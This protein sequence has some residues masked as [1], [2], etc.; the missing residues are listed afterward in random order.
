MTKTKDTALVS[1]EQEAAALAEFNKGMNTNEGTK[2]N[3]IKLINSKLVQGEANPDYGKL[4]VTTNGEDVLCDPA[5]FEF[6][7]LKFR[8]RANTKKRED[9][10][11][12]FY[13]S[14]EDVIPFKKAMITIFDSNTKEQLERGAYKDLKEKYDLTYVAVM[15]G[16]I[17][18]NDEDIYKFTVKGSSFETYFPTQGEAQ[19]A[20]KPVVFKIKEIV[21]HKEGNIP[22]YEMKFFISE[23]ISTGSELMA[24]V[25][26]TRK[27]EEFF[28]GFSNEAQE[29]NNNAEVKA[30]ED[31]A[32]DATP[33]DFDEMVAAAQPGE[34]SAKVK[35][36]ALEALSEDDLA[37]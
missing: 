6:I 33:P 1:K 17:K 16:T 11:A 8:F 24:V 29:E 13:T 9:D 4:Q 10:K 25:N 21:E 36:E 31:K 5:G 30:I 32:G 14:E 2:P 7:P 18:G 28:A 27:L 19:K 23:Q 35:K 20:G 15:Y 12:M 37:I 22:F 3:A 26:N 34:P